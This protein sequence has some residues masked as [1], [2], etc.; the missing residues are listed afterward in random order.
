MLALEPLFEAPGNL[1]RNL[2]ANAVRRGHEQGFTAHFDRYKRL[3]FGPIIQSR[4]LRKI[5]AKVFN[6][7]T[8]QVKLWHHS[9]VR[10]CIKGRCNPPL[11]YMR[12][13][14]KP[15]DTAFNE[16]SHRRT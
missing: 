13:G 15:S 9:P 11:G 2:Y 12:S 3:P 14:A 8:D 7:R 10:M 16:H 6:R 5:A 4:T 1:G